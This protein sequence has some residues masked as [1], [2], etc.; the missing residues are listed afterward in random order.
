ML[1]AEWERAQTDFFE[2]FK[3]YDE[4]G[5]PNRIQCLRYGIVTHIARIKAVLRYL[6]LS[7]MLMSSDI[8]PFDSQEIKPYKNDPQM[9]S[10]TNLVDAYHGKDV[11]A[12]EKVVKGMT[13]KRIDHQ[14]L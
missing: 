12:F 10:L 14:R 1:D 6:V 4:A 8:D 13:I 5:H 2:A 9:Q 3:N 7:N 11:K